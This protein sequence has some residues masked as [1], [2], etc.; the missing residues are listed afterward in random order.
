MI[1][2]ARRPACGFTLIEL[3]VTVVILALLAT[4][5]L[6]MVEVSVQ[7]SKEQDLRTALRQIRNALDAYKLAVEEGQIIDSAN[8]SGYP[9]TLEA[10]VQGVPDAHSP[11]QSKIY[12]LRRLPRDPMERDPTLAAVETWGLRSYASDPDDPQVGD[13]VFDVY[14]KSAAIGL[15]GI[16]YREW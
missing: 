3:V 7:R 8:K 10:L 12:F 11:E 5:A 1:T 16:P 4:A 15:N 13:E 9:A 14:S 2:T 6:P